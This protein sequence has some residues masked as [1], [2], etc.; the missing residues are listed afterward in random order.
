[1]TEYAIDESN[2]RDSVH[3]I[4]AAGVSTVM[5]YLAPPDWPKALSAAEADLYLAA[6]LRVGLNYETTAQRPTEGVAA[7]VADARSA[8]G[9]ADAIGAP[10]DVPIFY[11]CDSA[12]TWPQVAA[13][14][15]GAKSVPGRPVGV[16]GPLSVCTGL[17][18]DGVGRY[19]WVTNAAS[20]SGFRT[21][22]ALASA[23]RTAPQPNMLQH[24]DRPLALPAGT[25]DLNEILVPFPR[26]GDPVEVQPMYNPPIPLPP[27][28]ADLRCPMGGAWTLHT[29]GGVA[30]WGGAPSY[31]SAA[32]KPYFKGKQPAR[33]ELPTAA[34]AA[35]G[36]KLV[37]V[38]T[39]NSRYCYPE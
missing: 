23:A 8:N 21:W 35:A 28:V 5:R 1:M 19:T 4:V 20:W 12:H 3:D 11:S 9:F 24:V 26:W 10:K 27:C 30:S 22:D 18:H 7:G 34:E 36:K 37:I 25:Y 33:L 32:G 2:A 16:Y 31:G 15:V 13:Y 14:Y 38:T 29:D 39:D 6:G 17:V